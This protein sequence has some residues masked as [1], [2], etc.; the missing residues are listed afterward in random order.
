MPTLQA[1]LNAYTMSVLDDA[2]IKKFGKRLSDSSR[3]KLFLAIEEAR[4]S[5]NDLKEYISTV[6]LLCR[7]ALARL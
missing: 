2:C 6:G 1:Q 4:A 7:L 3:Y 5:R